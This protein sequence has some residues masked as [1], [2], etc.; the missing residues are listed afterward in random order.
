MSGYREYGDCVQ[1]GLLFLWK[2]WIGLVAC[3]LLP[4]WLLGWVHRRIREYNT[5]PRLW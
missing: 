1:D 3:V 5:R 4:I 2:I